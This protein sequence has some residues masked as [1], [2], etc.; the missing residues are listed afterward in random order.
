MIRIASCVFRIAYIEIFCHRF[1]ILHK[2]LD[3][4]LAKAMVWVI[5]FAENVCY[6]S[7]ALK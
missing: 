3:L 4:R 2:F 7:V 6:L 5:I 1:P